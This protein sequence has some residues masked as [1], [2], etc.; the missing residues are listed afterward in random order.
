MNTINYTRFRGA[1]IA[2]LLAAGIATTLAT[3]GS[4]SGGSF[5]PAPPAQGGL[6]LDITI[7]NGFDVSSVVITAIGISFDLG[8]ITGDEFTPQPAGQ[9]LSIL[10]LT[11][12]DDL[13]S[14][15]VA[16]DAEKPENCASGGTVDVTATL[17]N[18]NTLTVGDTI[19]AFFDNCDDNEGF[20]ISGQ[21][22]LTVAAIQGDIITDVF[23]LGLDVALTDISITE[24]TDTV[25]AD[26]D[27]TIT[28]DNLD[29]PLSTLSLAGSELRFGAGGE[30]ITLTNF[31]HSLE[32]DANVFPDTKLAE[33]LGRLASQILG[34]T[35]DYETLLSIQA[36]G[37]D[38]PYTGEILIT[39]ANSSTVR[40]VIQDSSS[41]VLEID[42]NGDG[43]VDDF[44]DT[45]WAELSGES[46]TINSAN[47]P[48]IAREVFNAVTGFGSLTTTAG[49]QFLPLGPFGQLES[50]G[51]TGDFGA[52]EFNCAI[53]GTASL[54][55][56]KAAA[57]TFSENDYMSS[58][59]NACARGGEVLAGD[60]DFTVSSFDGVPGG[61][62]RVT[63]TVV[64]TGLKRTN[65]GN[66]F[67]GSGTFD[68]NYDYFTSSTSGIY[69]DS[70]A[71]SF[72]VDAG[73]RGQQLSGAMVNAEIQAGPPPVTITR[74]S[75]GL[76]MSE[77]LEGVFSYQSVT[78]DVFLLD[79]DPA[80]GPYSGDLLVSATDNS[81]MRMVALDE[82]NVRLEIDQD[83]DSVVDDE[84]ATTWATLAYDGWFCD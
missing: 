45:S 59:F 22:E 11:R 30:V 2:I 51:I 81:S 84:I 14:K 17:A 43:V 44:V 52:L 6:T 39:G 61:A 33:V 19:T 82:I 21:I 4:G 10:R 37:D 56:F 62:Y 25:T 16:G 18:P 28:V 77:D 75:S 63:G 12:I 49:F 27:V 8:E 46:S 80:T 73:G 54:S 15:P 57:G 70:F 66:C 13:V 79:E 60:M 29:F 58:A 71:A 34:G 31:D 48:V 76:L 7:A 9:G 24:G 36:T 83:G 26:G 78:P 23:L 74:Q 68:T 3:G 67:T 50:L 42:A 35:V 38:D 53:S 32:V 41:I 1:A 72:T 64:E 55:G 69:V 5:T 47:A 65:G 20:V 40:I